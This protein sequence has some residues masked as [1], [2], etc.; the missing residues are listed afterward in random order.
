MRFDAIDRGTP[1]FEKH[2]LFRM[3]GKPKGDASLIK[4]LL[5]SKPG[6]CG[7]VSQGL[8]KIPTSPRDLVS[9]TEGLSPASIWYFR[10]ST[11]VGALERTDGNPNP[12][13]FVTGPAASELAQR[14]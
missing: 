3:V 2:G 6:T 5:R 4:C 14:L 13:D 1:S 9:Y 8:P 11:G 7:R 10:F 12:P